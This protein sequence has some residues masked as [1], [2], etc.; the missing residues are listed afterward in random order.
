MG[1]NLLLVGIMADLLLLLVVDDDV[2]DVER[3]GSLM[4]FKDVV[5]AV[6]LGMVVVPTPKACTT[7][8]TSLK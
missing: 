4:A 8:L 6:P 1:V 7:T 3:K 5:D 2:D